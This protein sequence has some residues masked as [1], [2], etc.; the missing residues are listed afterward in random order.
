MENDARVGAVTGIEGLVATATS[1]RPLSRPTPVKVGMGAPDSCCR[2]IL[3][4]LWLL[5]SLSLP[6]PLVLS[7][8]VGVPRSVSILVDGSIGPKGVG[9]HRVSRLVDHLE[10]RT[11]SEARLEIKLD[12]GSVELVRELEDAGRCICINFG[13]PGP[14]PIN[15][16]A[17]I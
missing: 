2:S 15:N 4:R 13:F 6:L 1:A 9:G 5:L 11:E 10:T 12:E 17:I 7:L 16:V 8:T 14:I 3:T